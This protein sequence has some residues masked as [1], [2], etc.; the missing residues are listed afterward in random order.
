MGSVVSEARNRL[1]LERV[2]LLLLVGRRQDRASNL[3]IVFS[4]IDW[5]AQQLRDVESGRLQV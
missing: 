3:F 5:R 4:H 1:L 2:L